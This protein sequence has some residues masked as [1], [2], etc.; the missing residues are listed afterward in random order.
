MSYHI[1][2]YNLNYTESNY[3]T[4]DATFLS[5]TENICLVNSNHPRAPTNIYTST[6]SALQSE[7][8]TLNSWR[9]PRKLL[10]LHKK[11]QEIILYQF[12]C[13]PCSYCSRLMYPTEAR[14]TL[15]DPSLIYPLQESFPNIPLQFHPNELVS[16]RVAI[17]VSCLKPST[18]RHPP[19]V[20]EVP[21]EIQEVPMFNRIYL[22][23]VHLNCSLGRTP[24]SNH[25][26]TYRH[27]QGSIG[28]SRNINAFALYTGAIG[29]ILSNGRKNSWYYS[30]LI[31]ASRWL[32]D[33]N[34][35]FHP[36]THYYNRGSILGPPLVIPT[37]NL[38][39]LDESNADNNSN[40]N[41]IR[42]TSFQDIVISGEDFDPEIHDKDYHYNHLM[43]GFMT[44]DTNETQLP[45]SF[46]DSSLEAL[47][48]PDLFP[49]GRYHYA[50]IK[51]SQ[52]QKRY[53][54]DTY[55]NYIKLALMCPDS[56]FRL[57]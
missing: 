1:F 13:I 55:E 7:N 45:I 37:A 41:T 49:L 32:R 47:I 21:N 36:Y 29:A 38:A 50:D 23:P 48:F 4:F 42:S 15:Y 24:N 34:N 6:S 40:T 25:Y 16:S 17:C 8:L 18:R 10:N 28:Y 9:P 20:N 54:I 30:T 33:N 27:M 26:T 5:S 3:K 44:S 52:Q 2:T 51:E 46:S 53:N 35:F 57:H 12:S 11:F 31:N 14:W 22:S 56:R 43:A 19:K 39:S